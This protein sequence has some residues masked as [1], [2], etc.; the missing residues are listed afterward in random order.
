MLSKKKSSE[1]IDLFKRKFLQMDILDIMDFLDT[2]QL[3]EM[4]EEGIK[5]IP[6][7]LRERIWT[8]VVTLFAFT[9]QLLNKGSCSDA[10]KSAR[11]NR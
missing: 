7:K 1:Q 10:V 11:P 6:H 8:P 2:E 3:L 9:K 5:E 4:I